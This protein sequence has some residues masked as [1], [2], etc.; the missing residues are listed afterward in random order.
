MGDADA[1]TATNTELSLDE[2]FLH[3]SRLVDTG[4]KDDARR[5]YLELARPLAPAIY[6]LGVLAQQGADRAQ[7][8]CLFGAAHLLRPDALA[9]A[10]AYVRE[11]MARG[12]AEEALSAATAALEAHADAP[13][14]HALLG[15]IHAAAG[16]PSEATVSYERA[17]ELGPDDANHWNGLALALLGSRRMH[18]AAAAFE[19][20]VALR[21]DLADAW[22]NLAA[23]RLD[24]G[25]TREGNDALAAAIRLAPESATAWSNRLF[26][27]NCDGTMSTQEAAAL[28]ASWGSRL[29]ALAAPFRTGHR[30]DSNPER[31][32]RV[33]YVSADFCAHSV[34]FFLAPFLAHV[35]PSGFEVFC[36]S[37]GRRADRTTLQFKAF[38]HGWRDI[39]GR[40]DADV[41]EAIR[42]DQIDILVD[43]SGY[44]AGGRMSLFAMKPAPVQVT[45]LGYP[46]T[47]GLAEIDYRLTD[48]LVDPPGCEDL[49]VE[50]LWRPF[51][52]FLC[53]APPD[54]CPD[55]GEPPNLR[56]GYV[57]FG[58]FNHVRKL[59]DELVRLWARLL[60]SVPGSRLLLKS[61]PLDD[62]VCRTRVLGWFECAGVDLG[63][64]TLE[65]FTRSMYEHLGRYCEVDIALDTFPYHGTTTTCEALW[66]GVPVV[67]KR[68][69]DHR[70]RVGASL[71]H[72]VG[73]ADLVAAD[74][75]AFIE[76]AAG[77]AGD[78]DRIREL[79]RTLRARVSAA[80]WTQAP[81]FTKAVQDGYGAMWR[82]WCDGVGRAPRH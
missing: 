54:P 80:P 57:T 34:A 27:A 50:T 23:C 13:E 78:R 43:L 28:H 79:R 75:D 35:D 2:V 4:A 81:A 32:L 37:N 5:L 38:A 14:I 30:N 51:S 1:D 61:P 31:R 72:P 40:Q 42:S 3:A 46:H 16:R 10:V 17:V 66:M 26:Y 12:R 44:S 69:S 56:R 7:A 64:I 59:N 21:P 60:L 71:L 65:P 74:D 73:L 82:R 45:W 20:V 53:Y 24:Q 70:S 48:S 63:R 29:S 67:S 22:S 47:T 19:R 49:Y 39:A 52:S 58:S 68:G 15:A 9:F 11:L 33:G 18:D 6:G 76:I 8:L 55:P 41:A 77:L 62:S 25:L 36:Y